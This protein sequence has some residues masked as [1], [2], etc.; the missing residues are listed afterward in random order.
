MFPRAHV[1]YVEQSRNEVIP[2]AAN[3]GEW[4]Y[5]I[6]AGGFSSHSGRSKRLGAEK[7][8]C[9]DHTVDSQSTVLPAFLRSRSLANESTSCSAFFR[10]LLRHPRTYSRDEIAAEDTSFPIRF[11]REGRGVL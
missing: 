10:V 3:P 4:N 2:L 6:G 11:I 7:I 5:V 1:G 8:T 9:R